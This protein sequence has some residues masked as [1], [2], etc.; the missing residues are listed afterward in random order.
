LGIITLTAIEDPHFEI[1]VPLRRGA[2][3]ASQKSK[4][5]SQKAK[6]KGPNT[7]FRLFHEAELQCALGFDFCLLRF[8]F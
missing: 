2:A 3:K 5:K 1:C 8:A 7:T 6:V 4:R